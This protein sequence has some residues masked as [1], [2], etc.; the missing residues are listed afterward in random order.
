[1]P[2]ESDIMEYGR[3]AD[4]LK[5]Y[6]NTLIPARFKHVKA[7]Q[8][9]QLY[10]CVQMLLKT[11]LHYDIKGKV[12]K[13]CLQDIYV[14]GSMQVVVELVRLLDTIDVERV[15]RLVDSIRKGKILDEYC[16]H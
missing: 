16:R 2:D 11:K 1:M 7:I 4:R 15:D 10:I 14:V 13:E 9:N 12:A 8:Q 3:S 6:S 5:R